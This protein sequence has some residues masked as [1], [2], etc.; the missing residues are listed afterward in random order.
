[1]TAKVKA[2]KARNLCGHEVYF[3]LSGLVLIEFS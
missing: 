1:M 3:A 2:L